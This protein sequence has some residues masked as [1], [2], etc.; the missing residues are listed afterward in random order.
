MAQ[1]ILITGG[2]GFLGVSVAE[3]ILVGNPEARVILNYRTRHPRLQR[4]E[5]R[6]TF[7]TADLTDPAACRSLVRPDVGTILHLASLVS[8][9]AE[10]D[11][12][13]GLQANVYAS[14]NLLEACRLAGNGPRVVFPSSIASF[15]GTRMPE[16]VTDWTHQHPQGSYGAAK[17]VVEQLLND[18]SRK[19]FVDGRGL[20]LPAIVVRDEPNTAASGYASALIREP[21]RGQDYCCPVSPATRIPILSLQ[22]CVELLLA[23]A[24]MEAGS[25]GDYRTLNG[26]GL[27]PSAGEIAAAVC[28]CGAQRLGAISFQPDPAVE[29]IVTAWPKC[30]AAERANRLGLFG[31]PSITAIVQGYRSSRGS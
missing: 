24:E 20:R 28:G 5:G 26:P 31:D 10:A 6:V 16:T 13:A 4:L 12:F 23:C 11:F 21:L 17:V 15:G 3:R 8:G 30:M 19:G 29:R 1:S 14:L 22:R 27:S 2:S 9:G 18:Y 25:F 7:V